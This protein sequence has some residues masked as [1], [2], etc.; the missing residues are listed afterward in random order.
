M[1][2]LLAAARPDLDTVPDYVGRKVL[3]RT[4]KPPIAWTTGHEKYPVVWCWDGL[5]VSTR[6]EDAYSQTWGRIK[7]PAFDLTGVPADDTVI[8]VQDNAWVT[9]ETVFV[10]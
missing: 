10:D 7:L 6:S 5:R 4:L 1:W 2:R 3:L 8:V 9:A